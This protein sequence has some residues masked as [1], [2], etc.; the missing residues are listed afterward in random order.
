MNEK[1]SKTISGILMRPLL[2]GGRAIIFYCG[3]M[4]RTSPIVA[5]H[6]A[7]AE[8]VCFETV[9]TVYTLLINPSPQSA[10]SSC[11]MTLAA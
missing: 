10:A 9:N 8:Q 7:S 3:Q 5:I 2:V 4:I 11:R 6:N 1:K